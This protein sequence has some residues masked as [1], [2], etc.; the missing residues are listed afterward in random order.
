[1]DLNTI[2]PH[3][4]YEFPHEADLLKA[5]EEL[6]KKFTVE[7]DCIEDYLRDPRLA[8]AYTAF[9]LATNLPKFEAILPWFSQEILEGLKSSSLI[10]VGAGPGTFSLAFRQW[11][12]PGE[13]LQIEN[14]R[15]MGEQARALWNGLYPDEEI[16]QNTSLKSPGPKLMLFGHSANEM[17]SREALNYIS[18]HDPEHI[19]FIEPG[20]KDFFP[21]MLEIRE[22]LLEKGYRV[23]YPCPDSINC[24][25]RDT[26]DWC[27]QYVHVSHSPDVERLSQMAG[28]DRRNLPLI[29][30]LYSRTLPFMG[31][32]ER[33]LR[34]Y[35]ETKFSFEWDVCHKNQKEHYQIQKRNLSKSEQKKMAQRTPGDSVETELEKEFDGIKR[36]RIKS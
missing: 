13:I 2:L 23:L 6:S 8:S 7:R 22:S 9:Y 4:L 3:L 20:T 19:L 17:G 5:I 25:L 35:P 11:K 18:T 33:V 26:E 12:G 34:V 21:K 1:M 16:L 14:S 10:D 36:V 29:V 24:P 32:H 28:K 30:H 27:H 31:T 15:L